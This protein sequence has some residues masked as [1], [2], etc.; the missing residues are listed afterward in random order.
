MTE[1]AFP[2]QL[3]ITGTSVQPN[4]KVLWNGTQLEKAIL[5]STTAWLSP[6]SI[7]VNLGVGSTVNAGTYRI[8]LMTPAP[9]GGTSNTVDFTVSKSAP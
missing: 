2:I 1:S 8:T 9:G 5:S 3:L 7:H 4:T 6:N